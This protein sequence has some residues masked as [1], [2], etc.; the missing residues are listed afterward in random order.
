MLANLNYRYP[1]CRGIKCFQRVAAIIKTFT[2]KMV[3]INIIDIICCRYYNKKN[4]YY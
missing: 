4:Y 1:E 3:I 2:L